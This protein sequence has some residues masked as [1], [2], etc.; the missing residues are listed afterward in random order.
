MSYLINP[1]IYGQPKLEAYGGDKV[2][3]YV[4]ENDSPWFIHKFTSTGS[5]NFVVSKNTSSVDYLIVAGGGGGGNATDRTGGGGGAGGLI[6]GT[7][8]ASVTSYAVTVGS[9]GGSNTAGSNSTFLGLTAIGGGRG[10]QVS[11]TSTTGGSGGGAYH[12]PSDSGKAGTSGQGNAGGNGYDS[13]VVGQPF[14]AGGGGGNG[15]AGANGTSA[16]GGDGGAGY[17]WLDGQF[18]AGGGGGGG[19]NVDGGIGGS[20][21]GGNGARNG[22]GAAGQA[23]TGSGGGGGGT[24][25]S[26]GSGGSGIVIVRYP[27]KN[28]GIVTDELVLHLDPVLKQSY[29]GSGTTLLDLSGNS[30]NGDIQ[31]SPTY[32]E[33]YFTLDGNT[34]R[35]YTTYGGPNEMWAVNT[36]NWSACAWF[37]CPVSRTSNGTSNNS[38]MILGRCGGIGGAAQFGLYVHTP[39]QATYG[40]PNTLAIVLRGTN[41]QISPSTINDNE[42]HHVAATWDGTTC[43][44]Y[45]DGQFQVNATIGSAGNQS[46]YD[47]SMGDNGGSGVNTNHAWE[48]DLS[49]ALVY[50]KALTAQE[51]EQNYNAMKSVFGL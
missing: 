33:P 12:N 51:V 41:T 3:Y 36:Q 47:L 30:R 29:S 16:K 46:G 4:D 14:A 9:G 44:T 8:S 24:G 27:A 19:E 22:S 20:N 21:V 18:Y 35:I 45:L 50:S 32:T 5:Q 28:I 49:Q 10:G 43:K 6:Y 17:Q 39:T 37:R 40:T 11:S 42:W 15:T 1:Y 2:E 26:G 38:N 23:N 31:G 48:G 7:A 25:G 34:Q 13:G